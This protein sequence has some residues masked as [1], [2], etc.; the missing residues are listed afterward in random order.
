MV[1]RDQPRCISRGGAPASSQIFGTSYMHALSIRNDNQ[2]LR[3]DQTGCGKKLH[4]RPRM[5]TR[6]LFAVVNLRVWF[7]RLQLTRQNT[8]RPSVV[9]FMRQHLYDTVFIMSRIYRVIGKCR[10]YRLSSVIYS[11][12]NLQQWRKQ[13]QR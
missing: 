12:D 13:Q 2:I 8:C 7:C 3:G 10:M 4:G 6:D 1:L 11:C 5:L 9:E